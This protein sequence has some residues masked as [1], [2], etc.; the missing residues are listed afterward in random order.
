MGYHHDFIVNFHFL[1]DVWPNK[2]K[3]INELKNN[4]KYSNFKEF[5][6]VNDND[7][8]YYEKN[9]RLNIHHD[10]KKITFISTG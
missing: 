8:I 1:L 3:I 2:E 5:R 9:Y 7:I 10:D 6:F 4:S